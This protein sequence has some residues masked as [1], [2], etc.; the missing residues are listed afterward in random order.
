MVSRDTG[1]YAALVTIASSTRARQERANR[2]VLIGGLAGS[3]PAAALL[4]WL[5][6]YNVHPHRVAF[7]W[8]VTAVVVVV[9]SAVQW[10]RYHLV[11]KNISAQP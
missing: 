7:A 11:R 1:A 4:I 9:N 2:I 8:I 3:V 6:G 5:L 10:L